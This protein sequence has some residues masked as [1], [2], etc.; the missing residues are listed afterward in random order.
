MSNSWSQNRYRQEVAIDLGTAFVR[1]ATKESGV[2]TIPTVLSPLLHYGVLTNPEAV[3][4]LLTPFLA[5]TRRFGLLCPRVVAGFSTN[6]AVVE[7]ETMVMAF[8]Q[9]GASA[10]TFVAEPYAAAIGADV[11]ILSPYAQMVVDIGDGVTDCAIIRDGEI[12][13]SQVANVGCGTFRSVVKETIQRCWGYCLDVAEVERMIALAGT[14]TARPMATDIQVKV[15]DSTS[16]AWDLSVR[17]IALQAM[18]EPLVVEILDTVSKLLQ[19]LPPTSN[20][21]IIESGILLTGGGALLPGLQQRLTDTTAIQVTIPAK[22]LD[23]VIK[24]LRR[25]LLHP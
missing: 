5:R 15:Q 22:P 8:H 1:V 3:A 20:C 18:I 14:Y 13:E 11:D 10:V 19:K 23:A 12:L 21:E 17:Q 25:M 2:V 6:L 9:A 24:G 4:N 7:R 16:V